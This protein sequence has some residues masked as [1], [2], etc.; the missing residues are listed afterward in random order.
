MLHGPLLAAA[1]VAA[2]VFL[3]VVVGPAI[4]RRLRRNQPPANCKHTRS[5][6]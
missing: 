3:S 6:R 5:P 1:I 4:G 2:W